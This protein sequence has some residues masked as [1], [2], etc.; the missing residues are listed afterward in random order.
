M[1]KFGMPV[2]NLLSA[3]V[4]LASSEV[5]IASEGTDPDLF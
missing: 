5:V 3:E 1:G 4:A 2:D